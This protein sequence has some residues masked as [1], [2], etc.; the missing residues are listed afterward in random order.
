MSHNRVPV[1]NEEE[2]L[3]A[4]EEDI[5]DE[6]N[7]EFEDLEE[8]YDSDADPEYFPPVE[9]EE[10]AFEIEAIENVQPKK[11]LQNKRKERSFDEPSTSQAKNRKVQKDTL[12][13]PSTSTERGMITQKTSVKLGST[14]DSVDLDPTVVIVPPD[15]TLEGKDNFVWQTKVNETR[16][17]TPSKNIIHITP[18]P[19]ANARQANE[20]HE[21]FKLF[22]TPDIINKI[23]THTNEEIIRKRVNYKEPGHFSLK[24]VDAEEIE[25]YLG[26]LI[27]TAALKDNHLPVKLLFDSNYCGDRYRAT[28]TE[29]RFQ[30]I[31]DCLRF[32]DKNSRETRKKTTKLAAISDIW[33]LFVHNCMMNYKPSSYVTIDEQLIG[34]R[35]KCPFR[36]YIPSKPNKY[37]IKL[38]MMCD[39]STKYMVNA[40]PYLGKGTVPTKQPVADFFVEKL[41]APTV[42]GSNRNVTIDN[43]FT[44]IPL[45][46]RLYNESKLTMVGTIKKNKRELPKAF[47]N[48]K[49]SDRQVGSSMFLFHQEI[50]AVSYK[51][52]A[53]KVVTLV[54][55]MHDGASINEV[56]KKPEIILTYNATKGSVDTFDQMC[57]NMNCSRKTMRWPLCYFYNMV[58]I[59]SI[60]AYVIYLHN[61]YRAGKEKS[62]V[63]SRMD[64]MLSLHKSFTKEVQKSRLNMRNLSSDLKQCIE[65]VVGAQPRPIVAADQQGPRR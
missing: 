49:F 21:C 19:T 46:K 10:I 51:P 40:L 27:L 39:N 29:R 37:G 31:T 12:A 32:D 58:N 30:F 56:S 14:Q 8:E 13:V 17:K 62:E 15:T 55:T 54:S 23:V 2:I 1:V 63:L 28:M 26:V 43:W 4:L 9:E 11:Q 33:E 6:D 34:F 45:A 44:S 60:N 59:G 52:K 64:F 38:V 35:G 18:G 3:E 42:S 61:C 41:V 65:R 53:N 48:P 24:D 5:S 57:Q 50:T 22:F 47:T 16:G 36:M 25:A 20:P 7:I